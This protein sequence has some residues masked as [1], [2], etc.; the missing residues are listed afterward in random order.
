M[1]Q[2]WLDH[3]KCAISCP[4]NDECP[5]GCPE[6]HVGHPCKSWFCQGIVLACAA[7]DDPDRRSCPHGNETNCINAGCC[8]T[9]YDDYYNPDNVPWCHYPKLHHLPSVK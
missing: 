6:P 1:R 8:W 4:C 2:C 3:D 7:E 9:R 5:D